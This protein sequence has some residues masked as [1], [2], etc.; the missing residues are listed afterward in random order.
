MREVLCLLF[1]MHD[2]DHQP[3]MVP[4]DRATYKCVHCDTHTL[5]P[6]SVGMPEVP[7]EQQTH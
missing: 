7:E 2:W 6:A 5:V 4:E 1:D 3:E